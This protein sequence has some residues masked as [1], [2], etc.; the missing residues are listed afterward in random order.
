MGEGWM[1]LV[2]GASS[3]PGQKLI[4]MLV[5]K[6]YQVRALTRYPHKIEFASS[7]G[8]EIFEGDLRQ[9]DTILRAC[10]GAEAIISSVTAIAKRDNNDVHTVD[11]AGNRLLIDTANKSEIKRFVFLSAYGAAKNH[12]LDFFR[13]K[14]GIEDYLKFTGIPYTILRPT[15]FMES[16]CARIGHQVM[17]DEIVTIYGNGKNPINFISAEDVARFIV[18]A[19]ENPQLCNQTLTIGGPQSLT[20]DKVVATYESLIGKKAQKKYIP[21]WQ[22]K[23]MSKMYG[24][25]NET[26]A[27]FMGMQY[28]LATSNWKVYMDENLKHFPVNLISLDDY[29]RERFRETRME[30]SGNE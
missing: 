22:L 3:K 30:K 8:I 11:D 16:W 19:L 27:R 23:W 21:S 6:G 2:A 18:I 17:N 20:F 24:P 1:I 7:L 13:I 4:P 5:E 9:P 12:P 28:D 15:A 25:M 10:E 29:A 26:K 14:F